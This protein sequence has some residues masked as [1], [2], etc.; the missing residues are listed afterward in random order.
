MSV[1]L[2]VS[3]GGGDVHHLAPPGDRCWELLDVPRTT[4]ELVAILAGD[5]PGTERSV[6]AADVAGLLDDLR[7][8]G[9]LEDVSNEHR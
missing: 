5:Y 1:G 8:R 6:I 9:L 2:V 7:S 3:G 4:D